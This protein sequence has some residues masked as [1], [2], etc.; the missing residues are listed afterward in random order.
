M[1]YAYHAT[2]RTEHVQ[3]GRRILGPLVSQMNA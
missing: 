3:E 2:E 1:E